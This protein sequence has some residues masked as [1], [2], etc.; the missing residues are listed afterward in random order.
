MRLV[1]FGTATFAVPILE[2]LAPHVVLVV[3]QPD[4]PT[5]RGMKVQPTPVKIAA[6]LAGIPVIQ[7]VKCRAK[8]VVELLTGLEADAFVVAAY[9][10]ILPESLLTAARRGAINFHGSILPA[11]RGAAPIQRAVADGVAETGV[12]VMQMDKGM[13]T[14]DIIAIETLA[15][16]P[17]ETAGELYDRL[18]SL[19]GRMAK[20]W[21]PKIVAGDIT[22][23]PQN[24]A[25]ATYAPKIT[26][27]DAEIVFRDAARQQ[28]NRFRSVTPA[29]GAFVHTAFGT[30]KLRRIELRS[31]SGEPGVILATRP[32]LVIACT[33]GALA[34]LEVQPEGKR[35]MSGTDFANGA[36]IRPGMRFDI[37]ESGP[38]PPAE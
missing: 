11:Y 3:T 15:V 16:G 37:V 19:S 6:E 33:D 1:F 10:Q 7:P 14:G 36:R 27:D 24:H 2:R 25:D 31:D 9:G 38:V 18:A 26:K 29:P 32:E 35:A 23:I 30:L 22:A 13:D 20:A 28:F 34:L 4:Q 5:G 21:M 17:E 8:E 12:T